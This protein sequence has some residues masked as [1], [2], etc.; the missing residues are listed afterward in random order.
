MPPRISMASPQTLRASRVARNFSVGVPITFRD[1]L[2]GIID[3]AIGF[4]RKVAD[5]SENETEA[6]R[7]TSLL[8]HVVSAVALAWE[9]HRIHEMRGDARRLLL[10]R[11]VIDHRLST[12][13]PFRLDDGKQRAITDALL[14][15]RALGM[16]EAGA[17]A[18]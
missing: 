6:R 13:D 16:A 17:L 3:S 9:A 15:E 18:A 7:A 5:H 14:G 1:R 11:L 2:R 8:Y 10:S 4:A 12:G